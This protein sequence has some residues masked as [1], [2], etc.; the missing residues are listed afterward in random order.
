MDF[1]WS[2][3]CDDYTNIYFVSQT[4]C[5]GI[6]FIVVALIILARTELRPGLCLIGI[7]LEKLILI[8]TIISVVNIWSGWIDDPSC[9]DETFLKWVAVIPLHFSKLSLYSLVSC[10]KLILYKK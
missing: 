4:V 10:Y 2:F 8:M 6:E 1:L 9:I 7:F 3:K 5:G